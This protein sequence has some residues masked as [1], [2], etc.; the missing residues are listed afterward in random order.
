MNVVAL[1]ETPP[2]TR[3]AITPSVVKR[4]KDLNC[5]VFLSDE[6]GAKAGYQ[7]KDYQ[8]LGAFIEKESVTLPKADIIISIHPPKIAT[9]KKI[10]THA[11]LITALEKEDNKHI[12]YCNQNTISLLNLNAIPRISRAQN[13]DILSSQ[14]SLAG[15]KAVILAVDHFQRAVPMMMTAAGMIHPA[16]ILI[17]GAGV[18]GL[19]A[20]ATAKR[21][22]AEVFA[23]DVRQA[24]R[25][26]VESL[27]ATFISV[28]EEDEEGM[29]S[30]G[31]YATET[32]DA[33]RKQQAQLIHQHALQAD[34]IITTALIPNRP[35]PILITAD[36][37]SAMKPGS[38]VID[39][40]TARGGN[41][42]LSSKDKEIVKH[43]V[44]IIGDS[45]LAGRLAKTAS[46]LFS[47]N[48]FNL[49]KHLINNKSNLVELKADDPIITDSVICHQGNLMPFQTKE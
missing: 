10:P 45:N 38:I 49:I 41:C 36:T 32:S 37:V 46:E 29:E 17:L 3:V 30:A 4:Y 23:F 2:E 12:Q 26:Q 48:I 39:M 44:T 24:A 13:M 20:I 27:G 19:Q 11:L 42:A 47:T 28:S 15:Y 1:C 33:Y 21:L 35:A 22:G 16:K 6:A 14:A 40:A 8:A 9:L 25:E 5:C 43:G 18:A 7:A 34:I 31:G